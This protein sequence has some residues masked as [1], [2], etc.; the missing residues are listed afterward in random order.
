MSFSRMTLEI[1]LTALRSNMQAICRRV[2]PCR[3]TAVVKAN[4]YGT[5]VRQTAQALREAGAQKFAVADINEALEIA[6]LG[7]P[8]QILGTLDAAEAKEAVQR[9]FIAPV[10]GL[11]SAR[12]LSQAAV[13]SR[14]AVRCHLKL[15][16]GMGR[17]GMDA[18]DMLE[19]AAEIFRLPGLKI[20]GLYSHLSSAGTPDNPYTLMQL[21]R[22]EEALELL[23]SAGFCFEDIHIG[24]SNGIA[25]YP[26]SYAAPFTGVRS[27]VIMY[28]CEKDH[29]NA[30]P[31]LKKVLTLKSRLAVCRR[32]KEADHLGYGHT[33]R[34]SEDTLVGLIPAGYA[35]GI[36]LAL[37]N[38]GFVLINGVRCPILGRVC[39]DCTAVSLAEVPHAQAGDE[40]IFWGQSGKEEIGISDWAELKS[41]HAHDILC[42][43]GRR[44]ERRY[45]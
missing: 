4:A 32:M 19:E 45:I 25:F 41:T 22:F 12:M 38:R 28:G 37:T 1:D 21:Q 10:T 7:L 8:V 33:C 30:L 43:I 16:T 14:K 5:G 35:D 13:E 2:S 39:M 23:T 3:V 20:T 29:L 15:D 17:F 11:A 26:R 42:A 36:P 24:A 27:G 6:D 40:V 44:V 31:G 18:R 34:L 9:G